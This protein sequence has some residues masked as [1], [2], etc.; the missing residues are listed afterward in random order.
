MSIYVTP[1]SSTLTPKDSKDEGVVI[2]ILHEYG[3]SNALDV[4][5]S[6]IS[7]SDSVKYNE[8]CFNECFEKIAEYCNDG[9]IMFACYD[10]EDVELIKYIFEDGKVRERSLQVRFNE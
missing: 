8:S 1:T 6:D 4:Y 9:Y 3:L 10:F 5:K 7:C 2:E